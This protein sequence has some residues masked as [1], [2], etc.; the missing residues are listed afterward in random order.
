MAPREIALAAAICSIVL[1]TLP[2]E[3]QTEGRAFI[4][5]GGFHTCALTA[6]GSLKCWGRNLDGQIGDGTRTIYRLTATDVTGSA[7]GARSVAAGNAHTC[8]VTSLGDVKCWGVNLNGQLG[9]GSQ[10][11][12]AVPVDAKGLTTGG[13][14]VTAG[15]FHSCAVIAAGAARCWGR[16][17]FG[18]LGDNTTTE[19][20]APVN[21]QGLGSGVATIAAG[22]A[23]TCVVATIGG[24]KCWGSNS[25]G[26]L[27]DNSG[28]D[29]R[30]PVDVVGLANGVKAVAASEHTCALTTVSGV[31]CWGLNNRGQLGDTT[32]TNRSTPV[33][34]QGLGSG[35]AAIA[36]GG[37][38]TCV[39]TT[40]G[41]VK[42]WGSNQFGQLGD[43]STTS[44]SIPV[45]VQGLSGGVDAIAAGQYHSC[46]RTVAGNVKCWGDNSSGQLGDNSTTTRL[47]PV[48]VL[49]FGA[50]PMSVPNCTIT[51]N[52]STPVVGSTL[53]LAASCTNG[54]TSFT[55][56]GCSSGTATCFASSAN[57]GPRTYSVVATNSAGAG[58]IAYIT[59]AWQS[60]TPLPPVSTPAP[61]PLDLAMVSNA[62]YGATVALGA[63]VREPLFSEPGQ[64]FHAV[65]FRSMSSDRVIL[66]IAGT[67]DVLDM[68]G[69]DSTFLHSQPNA[70]FR[71]Y[72]G[73][74]V[75]I[76]Q[77]L[78]KR[79]P[80]AEI[81]FTGHSL[82]G[83]IA[84]V[85]AQAT[86]LTGISFNAPGACQFNANLQSELSFLP[87]LRKPA[88]APE[89][90]NF[91]VYGDLVSTIGTQC[92]L[93]TT[94]VPPVPSWEID[95]FPLA[96][97]KPMHSLLTVIER[98]V[99][100]SGVTTS[101][102]PTVAGVA[103]RFADIQDFSTVGFVTLGVEAAVN[104]GLQLTGIDPQDMDAYQFAATSASPRV[105]T[106]LFP[107]L[108]NVDAIFR[109]EIFRNNQ[110]QSVGE[111]D[112]LATFDFGVD[113]VD[114]F[115]FFILERNTRKAPERVEPFTYGLTFASSGSFKGTVV[116]R[117]TTRSFE[118]TPMIEY[119]H[120]GFDHYFVTAA[121]DEI[122]ALDAGHF[123][124]W[125]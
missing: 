49:G 29:Q 125:A 120:A 4:A 80:N 93:V 66:G 86:G 87:V 37:S 92:G 84:Q 82:G 54:P 31:K 30:T 73:F 114:Q 64:G 42:C 55:W 32:R 70:T 28:A 44:S 104:V 62:A 69:A 53:S 10:F 74:A 6:A 79:F 15:N 68:L 115:R 91:R 107:M 65:A 103:L 23:H 72:V 18:E 124:G 122:A 97:F 106:I 25:D 2:A 58:P 90:R 105:R 3:A 78:A 17:A 12:S 7:A 108:L 85:L 109:L 52:S 27:G 94:F 63:W 46:A 81:T 112:E 111:F 59:V 67:D 1:G 77:V 57:P 100:N 5:A 76:V 48:D 75:T 123:V 45:D 38:H 118:P 21:V 56:G 96:T 8:A 116:G 83:A 102:G 34:V 9:D 60:A 47:A 22:F 13:S 11:G 121:A 119:Y 98:L 89:I 101:I 35:V 43:N 24:V 36:V 19:R 61:T 41:G 16:N 50:P 88:A 26:R 51:A 117:S 71:S 14:V 113:G 33:N 40:A 99:N 39:L 95:L 20:W 110:W